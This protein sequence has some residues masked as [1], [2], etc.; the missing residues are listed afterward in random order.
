M[1]LNHLSSQKMPAIAQSSFINSATTAHVSRNAQ[2]SPQ[3]TK[4]RSLLKKF[5][6]LCTAVLAFREA[7]RGYQATRA[8]WNRSPHP[9]QI[10]DNQM[11]P[12]KHRRRLSE[13]ARKKAAQIRK[14][15]ACDSCRRKKRR[16]GVYQKLC[17]YKLFVNDPNSVN[18]F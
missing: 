17:Y 6:T 18:T 4:R 2:L 13:S 3:G 9:V 15:G 11:N 14:I 8:A 12:L 10:F 16:V 5:S 1:G 7:G